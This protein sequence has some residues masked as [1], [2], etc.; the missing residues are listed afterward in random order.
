MGGVNEVARANWCTC[1]YLM[2][3]C[4]FF[5]CHLVFYLRIIPYEKK[6]NTV[7][8][9]SHS[10]RHVVPLCRPTRGAVQFFRVPSASHCPGSHVVKLAYSTAR[11]SVR[12]MEPFIY[13]AGYTCR[14]RFG[15]FVSPYIGMPNGCDE[16]NKNI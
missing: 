12:N 15:A 6:E 4:F 7:A 1:V 13:H 2:A 8:K 16:R 10:F 11:G 3:G 9:L 14:L 5:C